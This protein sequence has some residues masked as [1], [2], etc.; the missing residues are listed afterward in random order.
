MTAREGPRGAALLAAALESVA[1]SVVVTTGGGRIVYVNPAFSELTGYSAAEVM[2]KTPALLK[3]TGTSL[4]VYADLWRTI[5]GGQAWRG[6]L[7]NTR[8]EGSRY[9]ADIT[10]APVDFDGETYFVATHRDVTAKRRAEDAIAHLAAGVAPADSGQS[11]SSVLRHLAATLESDYVVAGRLVGDRLEVLA[12]H[13]ADIAAAAVG[14]HSAPYDLLLDGSFAF[15]PRAARQTFPEAAALREWD[16]ESFVGGPLRDSTGRVMGV[17]AAMGRSPLEHDPELVRTVFPIFASRAASEIERLHAEEALRLSEESFRVLIEQSPDA[18]VVIQDGRFVYVNPQAKALIGSDRLGTLADLGILS[19]VPAPDR[20]GAERRMS[21]VAGGRPTAYEQRFVRDDGSTGI[22]EVRSVPVTYRGRPAIA[23]MARDLTERALL[24]AKMAEVDRLVAIGTLASGVAHEINNPLAYVLAN[25]EFLREQL[26]R[27][28]DRDS[29]WLTEA[30]EACD[31]GILGVTR[32]RDIV[33]DLKTLGRA[34][35]DER[36]AVDLLPVLESAISMAWNEIKHSARLERDLAPLPTIVASGSRL[37]QVFLNVLVN[38]AQAIEPG[39]QSENTIVV[40]TAV[41]ATS[42][43]IEIRDTGTGIPP[44]KITRI[45]DPFYTTKPVGQGTGLGL[46]ISRGI[47]RAHGG[48]IH[49]D[50]SV[51]RGTTF[52]I[53]LPIATPEVEAGATPSSSLA[54]AQG[55]GRVLL[56][57]DEPMIAAATRRLLRGHC[58]VIAAHSGAEALAALEAQPDV[59]L[60]ISDLMMPE[61]TGMALYDAI[62][63]RWPDL[64]ARVVFLTGGAFTP[65]ASAFLERTGVQSFTKPLDGHALRSLVRRYLHA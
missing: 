55:S 45:F 17:L 29:S 48:E 58:E 52:R 28:V 31:E 64:Q 34:T 9:T 51:G 65:E 8:K 60:I 56:V 20:D 32:V 26:G 18:V 23:S 3:S 15:H 61:M 13:G 2:G 53:T 27:G 11:M 10:V 59:G 62:G 50:S 42:V 16:I 5:L 7:E 46:A 1:D 43:V 54:P 44:D 33:R 21:E 22:A 4:D 30:I 14:L 57:E 47:V 35:E 6:Q 25:L 49:V 63:E 12:V 41:E 19:L 40:R 37:A 39:H 24:M 36:T 38:A